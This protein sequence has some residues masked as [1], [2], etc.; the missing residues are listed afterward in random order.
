[1]I[2][3]VGGADGSGRRELT[4]QLG[5]D[6]RAAMS[7]GLEAVEVEYLELLMYRALLICRIREAR[8][9]LHIIPDIFG[10]VLFY[11]FVYLCREP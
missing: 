5:F 11:Y 1:M 10:R 8:Q 3:S 7:R 4:D 6:R 9:L 2:S